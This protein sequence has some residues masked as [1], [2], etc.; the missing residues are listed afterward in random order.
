MTRAAAAGA[1][2]VPCSQ[3]FLYCMRISFMTALEFSGR[4]AACFFIHV[5]HLV[6]AVFV[7]G[8]DIMVMY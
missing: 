5:F 6:L 1:E 2:A 4:W 3:F 7:D 8:L